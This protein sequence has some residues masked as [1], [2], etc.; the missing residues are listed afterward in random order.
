MSMVQNAGQYAPYP[1]IHI[2]DR[3]MYQS[4]PIHENSTIRIH[5][6][7]HSYLLSIVK[8]SS[9]FQQNSFQFAVLLDVRQISCMTIVVQTYLDQYLVVEIQLEFGNGHIIV[10]LF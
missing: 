6:Y 5:E 2:V 1:S 3:T 4:H 10:Q 9:I 7:N 8:W